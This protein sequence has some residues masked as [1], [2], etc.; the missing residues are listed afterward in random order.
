MWA[1]IPGPT[2]RPV[3][4]WLPIGHRVWG[5]RKGTETLS[6]FHPIWIRGCSNRYRLVQAFFLWIKSLGNHSYRNRKN[7]K[8]IP[9][10]ISTDKII[11]LHSWPHPSFPMLYALQ[12]DSPWLPT[13]KANFDFW[14]TINL[15]W[16][17]SVIVVNLII[18]FIV[19]QLQ[20]A[21]LIPICIHKVIIITIPF[22]I[23]TVKTKL[24]RYFHGLA[25]VPSNASMLFALQANN[26]WLFSR[27]SKFRFSI[28]SNYNHKQGNHQ[29]PG[30][31]ELWCNQFLKWYGDRQ[32]NG[33]TNGWTNGPT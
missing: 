3:Q 16:K 28:Y 21:L 30:A 19:N 20:L 10:I 17:L 8:M 11:K 25:I 1:D 22:I 14:F 29:I 7:D 24:V 9:V 18:P 33:R 26:L 4:G 31:K 6:N 12:T 27:Q 15:F 5:A 2:K 32:T 23:S 13:D